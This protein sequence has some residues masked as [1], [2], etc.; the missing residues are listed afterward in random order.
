M[1][2]PFAGEALDP[3]SPGRRQTLQ[4]P[5]SAFNPRLGGKGGPMKTTVG[6]RAS[7]GLYVAM[8]AGGVSALVAIALFI[9][10][11]PASASP[12]LLWAIAVAS[13]AL[14]AAAF[15]Q[16]RRLAAQGAKL[17]G[18][19]DIVSL[20]L[21]KLEAAPAAPAAQATAD[22]KRSPRTIATSPR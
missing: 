19:L 18:D 12:V 16:N 17:S 2:G 15:M 4:K 3:G 20:R 6:R 9:A 7:A 11:A 21:L 8:G 22:P 14:A 10:L 1:A 5:D 13:F